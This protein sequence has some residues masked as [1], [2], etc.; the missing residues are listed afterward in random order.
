M[1]EDTIYLH[2][3]WGYLCAAATIP[4]SLNPTAIVNSE[5]LC[6]ALIVKVTRISAKYAKPPVNPIKWS[7]LPEVWR[8]LAI[9]FQDLSTQRSKV[10]NLHADPH[11]GQEEHSRKC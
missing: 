8:K 11:L 4:S 1:T 9:C 6:E 2:L 5:R 3:L 10:L 7:E